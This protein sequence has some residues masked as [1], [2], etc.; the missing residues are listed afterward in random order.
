MDAEVVKYGTEVLQDP[1]VQRFIGTVVGAPADEAGAWLADSIRYKRFK[2]QIK[3]LR[4]A[5]RDLAAAGIDPKTVDLTVL[6]PL[7]EAGS[8]T[9]D[10]AMQDRW[11]ALLA[12]AATGEDTV[13][14][15]YP[16]ILSQLAP[17]DARVL[18]AIYEHVGG[19]YREQTVPIAMWLRRRR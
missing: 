15:A 4:K 13:S 18:H 14:P 11:A 19:D 2:A 12:N 16:S 5:Q 17:R 8:L 3:I 10:E 9:E 1:A 7:L 6:V